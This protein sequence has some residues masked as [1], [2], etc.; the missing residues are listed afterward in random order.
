MNPGGDIAHRMHQTD[1]F[2]LVKY[3]E[4]F[5]LSGTVQAHGPFLHRKDK[6]IS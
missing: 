1:F 3:S 5:V 6:A 2:R 4:S